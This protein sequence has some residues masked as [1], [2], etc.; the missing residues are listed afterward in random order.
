MKPI[1]L[2]EPCAGK[3]ARTVLRGGWRGD[4]LSLPDM[5]ALAEVEYDGTLIPDHIPQMGDDGR[6]GTAYTLA[7]MRALQKRAEEERS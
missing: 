3:L 4:T 6:L 7:Y 1:S 2:L 5:R